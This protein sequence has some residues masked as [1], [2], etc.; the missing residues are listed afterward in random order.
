VTGAIALGVLAVRWSRSREPAEAGGAPL[1]PDAEQRL[2]EE[3]A[4]FEG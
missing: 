4:R 3:L 1:D 2:D